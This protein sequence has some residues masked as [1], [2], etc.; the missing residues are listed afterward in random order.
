MISFYFDLFCYE[1]MYFMF[2][3]GYFMLFSLCVV[4][5]VFCF[6]ERAFCFW[7]VIVL[8][9]SLICVIFVFVY[10]SSVLISSFRLNYVLLLFHLCSCFVMFTLFC[11]LF[12]FCKRNGRRMVSVANL[13]LVS[14]VVLVLVKR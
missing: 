14:S 4:C 10:L 6:C 7:F 8:S 3:F 2:A 9:L 5:C 1:Y 12:L 11:V 13:V